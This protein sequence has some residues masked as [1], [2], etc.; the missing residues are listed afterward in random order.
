MRILWPATTLLLFA[1]LAYNSFADRVRGCEL[2]QDG[3]QLNSMDDSGAPRH[4]H[5]RFCSR[6]ACLAMAAKMDQGPARW[7]CV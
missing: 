7:F 3:T 5:A 1:A 6:D 4:V 2:A